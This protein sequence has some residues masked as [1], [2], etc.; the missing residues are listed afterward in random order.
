MKCA[1]EKKQSVFFLSTKPD[2]LHY[3]WLSKETVRGREKKGK[4]THIAN[5]EIIPRKKQ[6]ICIV[7]WS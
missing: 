5:V 4:Y 2:R 1:R 3:L 6:C 7:I